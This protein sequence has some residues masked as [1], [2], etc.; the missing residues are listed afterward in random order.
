MAALLPW[1]PPLVLVNS[2]ELEFA[3]KSFLAS[4]SDS[5]GSISAYKASES[6]GY[7]HI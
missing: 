5:L 6:M 7:V 2:P 1:F 4:T 3:P